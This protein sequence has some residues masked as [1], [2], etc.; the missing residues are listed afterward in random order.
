MSRQPI[1]CDPGYRWEYAITT[2]DLADPAALPVLW[3][4]KAAESGGGA[5]WEFKIIDEATVLGH[6]GLRLHM[7]DEAWEAFDELR[8]L[9]EDLADRP[10][11]FPSLTALLDE[12][13][14]V[15]ATIG[16]HRYPKHAV[17][18]ALREVYNE[19]NTVEAITLHGDI[20][21]R[22]ALHAVAAAAVK[23]GVVL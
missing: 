8:P 4:R 21:R 18:D 3:I 9:F 22:D 2:I 12:Y 16:G 1:P 17:A 14:F 6:P 10:L 15:D 19:I 5:A 11:N 7:F 13:G 23:R 20:Q